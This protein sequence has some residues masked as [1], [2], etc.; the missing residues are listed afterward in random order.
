MRPAGLHAHA[1]RKSGFCEYFVATM[2]LG[3]SRCLAFGIASIVSLLYPFRDIGLGRETHIRHA[4]HNLIYTCELSIRIVLYHTK[5]YIRR[6]A[7]WQ[8]ATPFSM[9]LTLSANTSK[10]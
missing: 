7:V 1:R 10:I 9:T 5:R 3:V 6:L 2:R 4:T 8:L